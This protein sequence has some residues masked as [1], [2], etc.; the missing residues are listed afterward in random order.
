[1]HFNDL[2]EQ[3]ANQL[4]ANCLARVPGNRIERSRYFVRWSQDQIVIGL[5]LAGFCACA[6]LWIAMS[7]IPAEFWTANARV[8][9]FLAFVPW[10][11]W[12]LF[13]AGAGGFFFVAGCSW[14]GEFEDDMREGE[15]L[16]L[17][18]LFEECARAD[19]KFTTE[20]VVQLIK[21][22]PKR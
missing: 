17:I 15:R 7:A 6:T 12:A 14:F 18:L 19:I 16:H 8:V 1:M 11:A 3:Q 20:E 2:T 5:V 22:V 21:S 10:Y 13:I 9:A 4:I